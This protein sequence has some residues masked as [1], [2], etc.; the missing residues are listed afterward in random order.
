V[1][2]L[3]R[4]LAELNSILRDA[5]ALASGKTV[6]DQAPWA[7]AQQTLASLGHGLRSASH[8]SELV[9]VRRTRDYEIMA[10]EQ[11]VASIVRG[12]SIDPLY[13]VCWNVWIGERWWSIPSHETRFGRGAK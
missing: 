5:L 6:D 2:W 4:D 9:V 13:N 8:C 3:D 12:E 1:S 10:G 11:P 7:Q